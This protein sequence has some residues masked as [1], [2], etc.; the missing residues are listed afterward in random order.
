MSDP[1]TREKGVAVKPP[2]SGV[3]GVR[4]GLVLVAGLAAAFATSAAAEADRPLS[5]KVG[6]LNDPSRRS[7][8]KRTGIARW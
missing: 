7:A 6:V 3:N 8:R 4:R 5:L 2:H 1:G